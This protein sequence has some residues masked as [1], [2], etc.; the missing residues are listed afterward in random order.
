MKF[1][2][3]LGNLERELVASI[4]DRFYDSFEA[5]ANQANQDAMAEAQSKLKSGLSK[6]IEGYTFKKLGKGVYV[7]AISGQLPGMMENGIDVGEISKMIMGGNRAKHNAA[8]GK[9]YVDVPMAKDGMQVNFHTDADSMVQS[10]QR[11][12][13]KFSDLRRG[14]V[15]KENRMVRRMQDSVIESRKELN[16]P[17][18]SFL[19]I[20]RVT[21]KS[22]WPKQRFEGAQAFDEAARK[23]A[24]N[25]TRIFESSL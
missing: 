8:E 3:E 25:F 18:P 16:D 17:N 13:V 1:T 9:D 14:G 19:T 6:W 2:L 20:R 23:F 10:F 5:A 15:R 12:E 24:D 4:K 7:L 11:K 22:V 21:D